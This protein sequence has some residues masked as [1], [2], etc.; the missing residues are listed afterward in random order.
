MKQSDQN[1]LCRQA[2]QFY[3]DILTEDTAKQAPAEVHEH[4]AGCDHC[5][6]EVQRL[7]SCLESGEP[8][9]SDLDS[10]ESALEACLDLHFGYAS[11]QVTCSYVKPFLPAMAGGGPQITI[12]TPITA[13]IDNCP[14]CTDDLRTIEQLHLTASQLCRLSQLYTEAKPADVTECAQA[15][16]IIND[17]ARFEHGSASSGDMRH[18]CTCPDCAGEIYKTRHEM[19]RALESTVC[20]GVERSCSEVRPEDVFD[21]VITYG[22]KPSTDAAATAD[23]FAGHVRQCPECLEKVQQLHRTLHSIRNRSDSGIATRY[24]ISQSPQN[25]EEDS[26]DNSVARVYLANETASDTTQPTSPPAAYNLPPTSHP[27]PGKRHRL[28]RYAIVPTAAAAA[29]IIIGVILSSAS[30]PAGAVSLEQIF[31]ATTEGKN[32]LRSRFHRGD[33]EPRERVLVSSSKEIKLVADADRVLMWDYPNRLWIKQ[34]LQSGTTTSTPLSAKQAEDG[35]KALSTSAGLCPIDEITD[36][37]AG[38]EWVHMAAYEIDHSV[39]NTEVYELRWKRGGPLNRVYNRWR[40]YADR[41][42]YLPKRTESYERVFIQNEFTR[43]YVT[44]IEWLSDE[45]VDALIV[46]LLGTPNG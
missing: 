12:P 40:V 34:D 2:Q 29:A 26:S 33:E 15:Q 8:D 46:E 32:V 27:Q 36:L 24:E 3:Y 11:R 10:S 35:R 25:A 21:F 31:E 37:P 30:P 39:A 13:H 7:R 23:T 5:Q 19:D 4:I 16:A 43:I 1:S 42:T 18:F 45:E 41:N 38:S 28:S 44:T 14:G 6:A 17:A 9:S 20:D 22:L